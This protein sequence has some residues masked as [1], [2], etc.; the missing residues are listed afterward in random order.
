VAVIS[1]DS[2]RR[3]VWRDRAPL[4]QNQIAATIAGA[5]GLDYREQNPQAGEALRLK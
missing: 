2:P 4:F 5:L 3:G 1:P